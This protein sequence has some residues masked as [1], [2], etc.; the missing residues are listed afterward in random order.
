MGV[1]CLARA[2]R[3]TRSI[4]ACRDAF[5]Q[6]PV[7]FLGEGARKGEG[8][9]AP[10]PDH[11]THQPHK[12]RKPDTQH[13][14]CLPKRHRG[15][16]SHPSRL[17]HIDRVRHY[18]PSISADSHTRLGN[19]ID[20]R[21]EC[22]TCTCSHQIERDKLNHECHC[23]MMTRIT[24]PTLCAPQ[25][26]LEACLHCTCRRRSRTLPS[27]RRR[28]PYPWRRPRRRRSCCTLRPPDPCTGRHCRPGQCTSPRPRRSRSCTHT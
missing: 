11:C 7:T 27:R 20:Y 18:L 1:A 5:Q 15:D 8:H 17:S 26:P 4:V 3:C 22:C 9:V 16:G 25:G 13:A 12:N 14:R 21:I 6:D 24:L 19:L 28:R 2:A 10:V 23:R